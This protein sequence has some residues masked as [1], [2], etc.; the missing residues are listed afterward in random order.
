M[1]S[2]TKLRMRRQSCGISSIN[3]DMPRSNLPGG[4][5]SHS[6]TLRESLKALA[7]AMKPKT[8]APSAHVTRKN[9]NIFSRAASR[10]ARL[11]GRKK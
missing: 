5:Y 4:R 11:F 3:I 1:Q 10:I 8:V 6:K 9:E 2:K 7:S